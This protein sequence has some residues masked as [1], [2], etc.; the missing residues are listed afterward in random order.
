MRD[1][2]KAIAWFLVIAFGG[3]WVIWIAPKVLGI[4]LSGQAFKAA[5]LPGTF[6]PAIAA[7]I[8]CKFITKDGLGTLGLKPNLR[9]WRYYVLALLFV[10]AA[11]L[12]LTLLVMLTDV[13]PV[14]FSVAKGLEPLSPASAAAHTDMS[15]YMLGFGLLINSLIAVPILLGEELGWRGFL[16][17][18]WFPGAPMVSAIATGVVWGLWHLPLNLTGYNFPSHPVLGSALFCV[19]TVF[20]SMTYGWLRSAVGSVWGPC[21]AHASFNAFGGTMTLV[22]F[23]DP[24]ARIWTSIAGVL[25]WIPLGVL[26]LSLLL[27]PYFRRQMQPYRQLADRQHGS[28]DRTDAHSR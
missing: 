6:A 20:L 19:S 4:P 3:A 9:R 17:P 22:L 8:V 15:L 23:P 28:P 24:S 27:V 10:P 5:I 13:A 11:T 16:Q 14:N 12:V 26:G 21:L 25:A 1:E 2:S 18:R 7:I